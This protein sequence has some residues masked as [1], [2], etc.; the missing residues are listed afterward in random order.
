MLFLENA[1]SKA[2]QTIQILYN[3]LNSGSNLTNEDVNEVLIKVYK[4]LSEQ[5]ETYDPAPIIQRL[6][7]YLYFHT[8]S[9]GFSFSEKQNDCIRKLSKIGQSAG[10]R[11]IYRGDFTDKSQFD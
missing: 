1:K 3:D 4:K 8:V 7:Q 2:I 5:S 9:N 11:G 10:L 6:V